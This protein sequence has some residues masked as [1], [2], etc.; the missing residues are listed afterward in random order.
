[1]ELAIPD[2]CSIETVTSRRAIN[3]QIFS[4]SVA[5]RYHHHRSV[6]VGKARQLP[7]TDSGRRSRA[8]PIPLLALHLP[9]P[10]TIVPCF[11]NQRYYDTSRRRSSL[12]LSAT[13]SAASNENEHQW[14]P[15]GRSQIKVE[16]SGGGSHLPPA[17]VVNTVIIVTSTKMTPLFLLRIPYIVKFKDDEID[18]PGGGGARRYCRYRST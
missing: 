11:L 14:R 5:I 13:P 3:I 16:Q 6:L 9:S 7:T 8:H 1:M 18:Y 12:A 2:A 10:G 17:L 4:S 15:H